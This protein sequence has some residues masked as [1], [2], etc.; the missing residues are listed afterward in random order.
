VNAGA[1]SSDEDP[2]EEVF[3]ELIWL[4][5]E[6]RPPRQ[7]LIAEQVSLEAEYAPHGSTRTAG[8]TPRGCP[9]CNP[10]PTLHARRGGTDYHRKGSGG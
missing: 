8:L 4:S 1:W 6:E 5:I 9:T 7:V 2:E 3:E 10:P